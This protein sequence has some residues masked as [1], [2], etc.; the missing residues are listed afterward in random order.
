MPRDR[1]SRTPDDDDDASQR[2]VQESRARAREDRGGAGEEVP[3]R[4][5][6]SRRRARAGQDGEEDDAGEE[7]DAGGEEADGGAQGDADGA[8]GG[9]VQGVR[10][11]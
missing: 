3:L 9:A 2:P 5:Q 6:E 4:R 7:A 10:E 11:G 8:Q 1:H